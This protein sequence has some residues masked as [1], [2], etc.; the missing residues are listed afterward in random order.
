MGFDQYHEPP[1]ELPP[2]TRTFARLCA[3]L[4]EEAEAI[5]WYEQRIAVETDPEALSVMRDAQGEEFKH[6]AMD[7][8]FL[9]RRSPA[10]REIAE[11]VLFQPGDIVEHGEQAE[12]ETLDGNGAD[13]EGGYPGRLAGHRELERS[14]AMNHLLRSLA[15]IS[16]SGWK[17]LDDEARER[18]TPALAARKLVDFSGPHGWEYSATNLGRIEPLDSAPCDGVTGA[19]RKVLPLVE[20]RASFAL[21]L[22]ELRDFDRGAEDA[23]LEPLDKAAHQMAVAENKAVFHG[24]KKAMSGIAEASPHKA[25]ALGAKPDLY[26]RP[27]AAAVERLL[28]NGVSGPYGLALG[29]D[30]YQRVVETAEHGGYPLLEHLR[31][32]PRGPDHLGPGRRWRGRGQPPRRRLPVRVRAGHLNRLRGA[33]RSGGPAVPRGELQ[34]PRGH[35]RGRRGA[36]RL[37]KRSGPER[38][39]PAPSARRRR[40]SARSRAGRRRPTRSPWA[41]GGAGGAT[42]CWATTGA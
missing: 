35:A 38:A 9:L 34:L 24:W 25:L 29:G 3:S 2:A 26:P 41:A 30:Q 27:V 21:A 22:S 20:L 7:L 10:W 12:A 16:D 11:G 32:D 31:E 19:R 8:E 42:K 36:H 13:G 4:T 39:S 40:P 33:R 1:E 17:E 28:H 6:F 15:P 23:D 18:L 14:A 5:G 37:I